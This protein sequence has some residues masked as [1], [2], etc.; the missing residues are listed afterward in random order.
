MKRLPAFSPASA[1]TVGR[2]RLLATAWAGKGMARSLGMATLRLGGWRLLMLTV[3]L[4]RLSP[5]ND[6]ISS[7]GERDNITG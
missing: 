3:V 5:H 4:R 6:G 2:S 7:I 1:M